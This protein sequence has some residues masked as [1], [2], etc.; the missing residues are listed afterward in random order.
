MVLVFHVEQPPCRSW[1]LP[2]PEIR[3]NEL[4]TFMLETEL[5]KRDQRLN[6]WLA[7]M[8]RLTYDLED[9]KPF[10]YITNQAK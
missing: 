2:F 9:M 4:S 10:P 6:V 5:R 1:F 3:A 7:G 8:I